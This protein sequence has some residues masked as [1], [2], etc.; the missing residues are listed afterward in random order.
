[1]EEKTK[2]RE[3][4]ISVESICDCDSKD[5][6]LIEFSTDGV[7]RYDEA[8]GKGSFMYYESEV[9]GMAGTRTTVT[10]FSDTVQVDREGL[11]NSSMQF[12]PGVRDSFLYSTPY[13]TAMMGI[14]TRKVKQSF[15]AHGGNMEIDYVLNMEH[16]A[17]S[18][19]RFKVNVKEI[20][21]TGVLQ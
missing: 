8:A 7:Y 20:R 3:V 2:G 5:E 12:K 1:M 6:S 11:I 15:D 4:V 14:N 17:V 21:N 9:T 13:G 10:I 16:L 18:R 19:N